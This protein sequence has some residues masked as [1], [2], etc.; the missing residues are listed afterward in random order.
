MLKLIVLLKLP[1]GRPYSIYLHLRSLPLPLPLSFYNT[2]SLSSLSLSFPYVCYLSGNTV[3][4][5][6]PQAFFFLQIN[7]LPCIG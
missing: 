3:T 2:L 5:Y 1:N 6:S 7:L 4:A